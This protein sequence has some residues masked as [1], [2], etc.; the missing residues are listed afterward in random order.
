MVTCRQLLPPSVDLYRPLF[1]ARVGQHIRISSPDGSVRSYLITEY[2][3]RWPVTD[4]SWLRPVDHEQV[5]LVTCTTFNPDD[6]RIVAVGEPA[7]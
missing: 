4:L 2:H 5:V 7:T 6:P 3:P 1:G